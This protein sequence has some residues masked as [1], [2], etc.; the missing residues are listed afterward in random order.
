MTKGP[1]SSYVKSSFGIAKSKH[2]RYNN[3]KGLA[4]MFHIHTIHMKKE[5]EKSYSYR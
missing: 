2:L 5:Y 3:D 1:L 4:L